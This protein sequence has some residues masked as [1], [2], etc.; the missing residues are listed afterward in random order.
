MGK[1][2]NLEK[3]KPEKLNITSLMDALTIILIFLL[4]NYSDVTEEGELPNFIEL[5]QVQGKAKQ[6]KFG[7]R[8]VVGEKKIE[9]SRGADK[10]SINFQNFDSE[11]TSILS[12]VKE[13]L[14]LF[15]KDMESRAVASTEKNKDKKI[16]I[17]IQADKSIPYKR[18]DSIIETSTEL[19]LN[20]ID[21]ISLNKKD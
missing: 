7:I 11:K 12:Q 5:P 2:I 17:S 14:K 19:S 10:K 15:K 6:A 8:V 4:V 21:F 20:Y 9:I 3:R 18:I 16:K 1:K 13:E